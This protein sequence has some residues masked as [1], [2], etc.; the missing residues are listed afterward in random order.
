[1]R[2]RIGEILWN[3]DFREREGV[4]TRDGMNRLL[5][6]AR[7]FPAFA[8]P[9]QDNPL[10]VMGFVTVNGETTVWMVTAKGFERRAKTILKIQRQLCAAMFRG[11]NHDAMICEIQCGDQD[12]FRWAL[13]V[14]FDPLEFDAGGQFHVLSWKGGK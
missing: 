10:A 5:H 11:L 4:I 8:L 1:M 13:A 3:M 6:Q 12:A 9:D 14:G 2:S 7:D